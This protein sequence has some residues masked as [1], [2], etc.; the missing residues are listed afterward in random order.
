MSEQ[1]M[2]PAPGPAQAAR[3][4][5]RAARAGTLATAVDGQPFASLVT[6]ATAPDGSVLLLLSG[7]S[8]HTRHLRA[9]PR[10][11]VMVAGRAD[12]SNAQTAPRL[13]VTGIAAPEA[14]PAMKARWVAL[15]PYAA[16]YAGFADFTLWR[17]TPAAGQFIGG[18]ASAH[19]LKQGDLVADT[20]AWRAVA[21]AEEGVI[22]H[23]NADHADTLDLY[24]RDRGY[25]GSGWRMVACDVDG[26]DLGRGEEVRRID[27][28]EP[29]DGPKSIRKMLILLAN[30]AREHDQTSDGRAAPPAL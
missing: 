22:A 25:A 7:L 17:V 1:G 14:D 3:R 29:A 28:P 11:A 13:T 6:P 26:F 10:C 23:C 24:A 21:A 2:G 20:D 4:L 5:L 9:E 12:G 18:F 19:R 8:E 15:H 30:T 27:W 16:F